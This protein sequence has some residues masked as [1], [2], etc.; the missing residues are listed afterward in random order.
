[1]RAQATRRALRQHSV[2]ATHR[3]GRGPS[4]ARHRVV[5]VGRAR[6][7]GFA[8]NVGRPPD[9]REIVLPGS[10]AARGWVIRSQLP[11]ACHPD[12]L[13]TS[14]QEP[15]TVSVPGKQLNA[16]PDVVPTNLS[17]R[18]PRSAV[19]V[20]RARAAHRPEDAAAASSR[21][22]RD[23]REEAQR[24]AGQNARAAPPHAGGRCCATPSNYRKR[25]ATAVK[26]NGGGHL[27]HD[28]F[29]NWLAPRGRT[30][31]AGRIRAT[32]SQRASA[33]S[34]NSA[35]S[36]AT[37]PRNISPAAGWRWRSSTRPARSWR[38]SSSRITRCSSRRAKTALLILDVWEHAYYLKYQ[39]RRPEF[40]E[41]FWNVVN[42]PHVDE[43][44]RPRAPRASNPVAV[45]A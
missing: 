18:A 26:N 12:G 31:A 34:T 24:S 29:W 25:R 36:S 20:R 45:G 15:V 40:I 13:A 44:V 28:L 43:H 11:Q 6:I 2:A 37:R 27:N 14:S 38:S 10:V 8:P 33:R 42:W 5:S 39:N 30:C 22:S 35:R 4:A 9:C 32:R 3:C 17:V 19:R 1:M 7:R 41:A 21:P 16:P 23:L